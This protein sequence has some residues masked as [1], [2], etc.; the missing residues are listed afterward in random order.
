MLGILRCGLQKRFKSIEF[1]RNAGFANVIGN[2][3]VN[4]SFAEDCRN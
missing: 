1:C 3:C 2:D 4:K